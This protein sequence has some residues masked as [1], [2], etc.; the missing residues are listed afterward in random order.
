[1]GSGKPAEHLVVISSD[2]H[3]TARMRDYRP[4]L[5]SKWHE[6]FDAFVAEYEQVGS[7]NFEP[8]A[9]LRRC[10]PETVDKWIEETTPDRLDGNSDPEKRLKECEQQ[11]IVAEVLFPDFGLPFEMYA[12]FHAFSLGYPP[13]TNEEI[14]VANRAY[15]RWLVDFCSY[16]PER[17][18]PLA[19]L[20]F[21]DVEGAVNEIQWL[22]NAG[23]KGIV[24][25]FFDRESP[26]F[27]PKF[28]PIWSALSDLELIA[29]AHQGMSGIESPGRL[30]API[31]HPKLANPMYDSARLARG[32]LSH[33]IWGGVLERHPKLSVVFTEMGSGWV[34]QDLRNMDY[35]YEGSYLS[36]EIRSV[37]PLKPSEYFV[38]QCHLGSSL[39]SLPEMEARHQI[40]LD[41]IMLGFDYPHHE[42]AWSTGS[43]DYLQ[44]TLGAAHVPENEARP[45]LGETAIQV[46]GFDKD[47]LSAF[48]QRVGVTAQE[49][50]KPPVED[51]FP[52]GDVHRPL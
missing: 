30:T 33:M 37:M 9:L 22:K 29:N 10:D 43:R 32:L 50:L 36:R 3:A 39:F 27:H 41:K 13:R 44:A 12:T 26:V 16:A 17:F 15:A 21:D 20:R 52:R 7:K 1:M 19:P 46:Y 51:K 49:I 28:D 35:T 40:G 2:G 45:M 34:I 18:A 38:R 4:Y 8:K 48:A 5:E 11:G 31:P 23:F 47:R 25:P 6:S 14:N 24:L 42:G